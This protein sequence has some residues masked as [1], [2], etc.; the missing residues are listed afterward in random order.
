MQMPPRAVTPSFPESLSPATGPHGTAGTE[1]GG[2]RRPC[3]ELDHPSDTPYEPWEQI[4]R[5]TRV[6][7]ERQRRGTG[8][9]STALANPA[10]APGMLHS[11]QP[12]GGHYPSGTS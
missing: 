2:S 10:R 1:W 5:L 6:R 7:Q 12:C 11:M 9:R 8:R 4:A 3:S